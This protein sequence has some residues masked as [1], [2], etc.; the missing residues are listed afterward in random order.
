[1]TEQQ[2][3]DLLINIKREAEGMRMWGGM[4]WK[5]HNYRAQRIHTLA[6]KAL[7]QLNAK[8]KEA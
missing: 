8:T 5:W 4:G 1:M 6:D 2:V 7:D 3:R